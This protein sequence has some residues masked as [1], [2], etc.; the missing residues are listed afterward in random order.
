ML[1]DC[2]A[3]VF[4]FD[5]DPAES[6]SAALALLQ[7]A[8]RCFRIDE[9]LRGECW[10]SLSARF[11]TTAPERPLAGDK[12]IYTS[13]TTGLPRAVRRPLSGLSLEQIGKLAAVAGGRGG[14]K[15]HMAQ[16]GIPDGG[17]LPDALAALERVLRDHLSRA[18]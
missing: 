14:G 15:P 2:A 3:K 17:R 6:A 16:A 1:S 11:P 7:K 13:G 5:E 9:A 8:P 10:R 12:L 18:S 4:V